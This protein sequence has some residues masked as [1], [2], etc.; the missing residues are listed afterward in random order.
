MKIEKDPS[1]VILDTVLETWESNFG[2]NKPAS[3]AWL[4]VSLKA[5]G[6]KDV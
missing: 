1:V 5:K 6:Q 2:L 3:K 4:W